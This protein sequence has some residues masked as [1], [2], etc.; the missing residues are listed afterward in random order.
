MEHS[1]RDPGMIHL[2]AEEVADQKQRLQELEQSLL[3]LLVPADAADEG[4]AIVE[5]RAG[6]GGDEA[7]LFTRD[8]LRMYERYSQLRGWK[9][10]LM[11]A[12]EDSHKGL[13]VREKKRRARAGSRLTAAARTRRRP[14]RARAS[15]VG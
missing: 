1:A 7:A 3:R 13:R 10:E 14:W 5:V 15:S 12:T 2:A 8:I 4:S 6:T 9:F 11:S